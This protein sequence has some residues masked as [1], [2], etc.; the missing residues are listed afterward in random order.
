MECA[1]CGS[2]LGRGWEN[3]TVEC[4]FLFFRN[5]GDVVAT[6]VNV[7]FVWYRSFPILYFLSLFAKNRKMEHFSSSVL[8]SCVQKMG[9]WSVFHNLFFCLLCE[10]WENRAFFTICFARV[11]YLPR[12]RCLFAS[13]LYIVWNIY[14]VRLGFFSIECKWSRFSEES[15]NNSG[16]H[17][18][19]IH[20]AV[21]VQFVP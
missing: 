21:C 6:V 15:G 4:M 10:K 17:F 11:T 3:R 19:G 9:K 1:R 2:E 16:S 20:N 18:I 7:R 8:L 12:E 5:S 14:I 13:V